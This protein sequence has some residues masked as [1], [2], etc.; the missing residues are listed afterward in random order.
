MDWLSS[1]CVLCL[2]SFKKYIY[3]D[4]FIL[5]LRVLFQM[6]CHKKNWVSEDKLRFHI[7]IASVARSKK[8]PEGSAM[9]SVFPM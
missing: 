4:F 6:I 9:Y 1:V 5:S 7:C 3:T 2:A 8:L